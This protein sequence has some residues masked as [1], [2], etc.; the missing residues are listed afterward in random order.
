M[1]RDF[2]NYKVGLTRI[3][4]SRRL[5][6]DGS[7]AVRILSMDEAGLLIPSLSQRERQRVLGFRGGRLDLTDPAADVDACQHLA[8]RVLEL[9]SPS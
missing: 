3:Y 8:R 9:K 2:N 5:L 6:F 7:F 4:P 1:P